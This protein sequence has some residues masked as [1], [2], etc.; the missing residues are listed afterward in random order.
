VLPFENASQNPQDEFFSFGV[1]EELIYALDRLPGLEVKART[2]TW[3]FAGSNVS[4]QQVA[5]SIGATTVLAGRVRRTGD[6]VRVSVEL[7]R[8][9]DGAILWQD[10]FE[11][12][13][14]DLFETRGRIAEGIA[15]TLQIRLEADEAAPVEV[16]TGSSEAY[17]H[18]LRGRYNLA[19]RNVPAIEDGIRSF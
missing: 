12:T 18:F 17:D 8:G 2:S 13:V 14:G 15:G 1:A 11:G 6:D 3:Q 10:R 7:V 5:D 19:L 16:R 4:A 9:S